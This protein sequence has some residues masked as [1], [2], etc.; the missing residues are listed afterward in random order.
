MVSGHPACPE[1]L[2]QTLGFALVSIT[3]PSYDLRKHSSARACFP[4]QP[5]SITKFFISST[6]TF[7]PGPT[8]QVDSR[9]SISAGPENVVPVLSA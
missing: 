7:A 6:L 1:R 9:S 2:I 8:T 3:F 5:S 4:D